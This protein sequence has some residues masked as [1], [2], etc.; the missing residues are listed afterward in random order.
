MIKFVNKFAVVCASLIFLTAC[1]GPDEND[2][3]SAINEA[4]K[5]QVEYLTLPGHPLFPT[6]LKDGRLGYTLYAPSGTDLYDGTEDTNIENYNHE[7][8]LSTPLKDL[9]NNYK[10]AVELL[11]IL[12]KAGY[13]KS[14]KGEFDLPYGKKFFGYLYT[15]TEKFTKNAES[16]IAKRLILGNDA[17]DKILEIIPEKEKIDDN[18][19]YKVI[20]TKTITN[21]ADGLTAD[22]T[23]YDDVFKLVVRKDGGV[24]KY[25]AYVLKKDGKYV[26]EFHIW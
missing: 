12:E 1:G 5:D 2:C 19:Y 25:K 9:Q 13:V 10:Q 26:A 20:F 24:E 16:T 15:T 8:Y 4:L 6:K 23:K 21:I 14:E 22:L 3:T 11:S 17:V 7:R 18:K